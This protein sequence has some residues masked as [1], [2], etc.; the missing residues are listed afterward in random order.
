MVKYYNLSLKFKNFIKIL[1][2]IKSSKKLKMFFHIEILF[3]K[4]QATS[5]MPEVLLLSPT[6][7][8]KTYS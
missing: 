6:R 5:K 7:L 1:E 4:P 3:K 2:D 8:K